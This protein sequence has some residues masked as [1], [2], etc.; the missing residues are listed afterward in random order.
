MANEPRTSSTIVGGP[1]RRRPKPQP[2]QAAQRFGASRYCRA[3]FPFGWWRTPTGNERRTRRPTARRAKDRSAGRP[4]VDRMGSFRVLDKV[5]TLITA[6]R[7][8]D[9]EVGG[10][11]VVQNRSDPGTPD[12]PCD[13]ISSWVTRCWTFRRNFGLDLS[14]TVDRHHPPTSIAARSSPIVIGSD[15][16]QWLTVPWHGPILRSYGRHQL[17]TTSTP[18]CWRPSSQC[19]TRCP[20]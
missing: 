2:A 5:E 10:V 20:G 16:E 1:G 3:L 9:Y 4:K 8:S 11:D 19:S 13:R 17:W 14:F 18:R 12:T 7:H 6:R 15:Q